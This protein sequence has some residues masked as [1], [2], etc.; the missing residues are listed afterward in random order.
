MKRTHIIIGFALTMVLLVI[1]LAIMDDYGITW[2]FHHH[3]FAGLYHLGIPVK[4]SLTK[5]IPFTVPD[6][7]GTYE[8]P[9]GPLML[10]APTI[11]YQIFHEWLGLLAFDNAYHLSI[12]VSGVAGIF[13]LYLFLLE[14]CGLSTAIAGFLFLA[15]L[16]R[17]FGDLHNNMKDVPQAA[18][19]ALAIYTFWRLVKHKR[20]KALIIASAAFAIAFNTKVNTL[21]VPVIVGIWLVLN[22]KFKA[23]NSKQYQNSNVQNS[24]KVL[25][26][27]LNVGHLNLFRISDFDIRIWSYFILAPLV[28]FLLWLPFWQHPI[29]R[30]QYMFR[31]FLDNTQNLEVLYFGTTYRSAINVPWHY[32][33]GYLAI[34]TPIPILLFFLIGLIGL[35]SQMRQKP[36]SSLL[37]LWF[38][39]P[40]ARYLNP[41]IGV[42]DGIRHFEEVV[43][44]L[45]A[46]A[47]V[48]AVSLLRR[49]KII[50]VII[51]ITTIIGIK[52][53]FLFH[54]YQIS[55]F[56]E[57]VGGTRGAQGNFDMEYWGTS[58]KAAMVWLNANTP[59]GSYVHIVMAADAAAKYLRP[60]LLARVNQ[61]GFDDADYVVVL[62]RESFFNRYWG[63][64]D[65]MAKHTVSHSVNVR[66]VPLTF[67]YDNKLPPKR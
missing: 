19:F 43:Y 27:H 33:L 58:Q 51:L 17:Y 1:H 54:P 66:G 8:L 3:F 56:N 29:E 39:L 21:F 67:I 24:K 42:I 4:E 25:F 6:P 65:Y 15:L 36:I 52:D 20:V 32:P 30:L 38:F 31:F 2:D 11:T 35:I 47:A 37:I 34:T 5:H 50:I 7:R 14:A 10:I 61:K 57:L 16:P 40:L 55:Y 64:T 53:I 46:I 23:R 60:D 44:P 63:I 62:N 26:A 48:G 41:N 49:M 45:A 22:S 18:A 28:A 9:F 12:I 13:I 59:A